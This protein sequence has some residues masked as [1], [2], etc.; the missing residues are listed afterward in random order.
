MQVKAGV[1]GGKRKRRESKRESEEKRERERARRG[2]MGVE[3]ACTYVAGGRDRACLTVKACSFRCVSRPGARMLFNDEDGLFLLPIIAFSKASSL[4]L[5]PDSV[6]PFPSSRTAGCNTP[7]RSIVIFRSRRN[8]VEPCRRL[9]QSI[10]C[11]GYPVDPDQGGDNTV[12][13]RRG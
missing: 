11:S 13:V 6:K 10:G 2:Q 1:Q 4:P 8:S 5:Q 9:S 7:S 12:T 3:R